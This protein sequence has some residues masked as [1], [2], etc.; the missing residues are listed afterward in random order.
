METHTYYSTDHVAKWRRKLSSLIGKLCLS[1]YFWMNAII[2]YLGCPE[3]LLDMP[4]DGSVT[5]ITTKFKVSVS[6]VALYG[7]NS[8]IY[9]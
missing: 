4:S 9:S 2:Q 3:V 6:Q 5:V 1:L 7:G 8:M